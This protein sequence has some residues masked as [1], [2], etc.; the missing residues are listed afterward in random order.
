M[1]H[2]SVIPLLISYMEGKEDSRSDIYFAPKI[3]GV[4]RKILYCSNRI[5]QT[6]MYALSDVT[7][8]YRHK[9]LPVFLAVATN[10][11]EARNLRIAAVAMIMK[12]RPDTV[13][14]QK[15]AVSTWFEQD[16]E[17]AR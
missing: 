13:Q 8:T 15:L 3:F 10:P 11:A 9:L 6:A 2:E 12:C 7:Q 14:L 17:V 16:Q 4:L 5:R 1:A